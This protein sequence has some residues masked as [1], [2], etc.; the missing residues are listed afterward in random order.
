MQQ[1][2]NASLQRKIS[3]LLVV[4]LSFLFVVILY[5]IFK[6]KLISAEM[7]E[8]A[9]IDVP[10]TAM[11][12]ELEMIQLKQHL[13]IDQFRLNA[14]QA[15]V[16][17]KPE[18]VFA[19]QREA[20]KTLL[21]KTE[22]VLNKSLQQHQVRFA[23]AEHQQILVSI[24]QFHQQSDSFEQHLESA[25][26]Q[27]HT[28]EKHW[29]KFEEEAAL[30]DQSIMSILQHMEKLTLEASRY[31]DKHQNEFM[32]VNTGLGFCAFVI[33]L[34]LT[35]YILQIFRRR[36]GRIQAEI[37][38]VQQSIE[39]GE[40]IS[41]PVF[42]QP[43]HQDELTELEHDLKMMVQR[44]SVEISNRQEIEQQLLVLATRDKLTGAFNRHKWDEQL[45]MEL[46]L[47]ERGGLFSIAL[48]DVDF[49]KKVNDQFGH[50]TGDTVL[51]ALTEHISH[52]L[53][54][55]DSLFRL[56][57]EE[58]VIL[59]PQQK[60]EAACQLAEMLRQHIASLDEQGLPQFTISFG[61]TEYQ[62]GDDKDSVLKRADQALYQAK[63]MGRNKVQLG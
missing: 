61:V 27:G 25:L 35:F 63:A 56:G 40:P 51:Q 26:Q 48:L 60:A 44:L 24:Q 18:Q 47:A 14:K 50:H 38:N 54:K 57:G 13:F 33:G 42:H 15:R 29:L 52:R 36:I 23:A 49:F 32:L 17:L 59:L 6:L 19:A 1:W 10:L 30:L 8:V 43:D 5:S 21:D 28:T 34:Y 62:Q 11:V 9:E 37:K 7:H 4:L 2:F 22:L 58:F 46:S 31:T 12:S 16:E 55:T 3:G 39:L 45:R 53:R 20:L 41:S